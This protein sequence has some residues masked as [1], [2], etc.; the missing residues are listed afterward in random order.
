MLFRS[1]QTEE[2]TEAFGQLLIKL[3]R[4]DGLAILLVEH[5]M[6]LVMD[7]C[8]RLFVLDFGVIIASGTPAEIRSNR[9][10][11]DA[12]LGSDSESA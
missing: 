9:S 3:A 11:L 7:I 4:E 6:A 5:D 2:E 8:D 12:Y 1:G 10:V